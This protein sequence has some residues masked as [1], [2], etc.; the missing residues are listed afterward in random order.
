[1]MDCPRCGSDHGVKNG[2]LGNGKP[3]L[4]CQ[5]GGRQFV[6]DPKR[7]PISEE[8][9]ALIDK[10]LLERISLAGIARVR[11]VSEGQ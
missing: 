4:K 5:G 10:L 2:Y 9:R 6:E 1:M 11:G 7:Q 8:S 3:K